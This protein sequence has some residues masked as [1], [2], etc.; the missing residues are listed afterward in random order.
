M[1]GKESWNAGVE[2]M[3]GVGLRIMSLNVAHGRGLMPVGFGSKKMFRRNLER[4]AEHIASHS[5]DIVGL[6]EVDERATATGRFNHLD[7]IAELA[8]FEHQAH[9]VHSGENGIPIKGRYGTALLSRHPIVRERSFRF[10][11]SVIDWKGA[12]EAT[13]S[14]GDSHMRAVS[15]HLDFLRPSVRRRQTEML[16]EWLKAGE[17]PVVVMGDFNCSLRG[18][19]DALRTLAEALELETHE[20]RRPASHT[21]PSISPKRRID[22]IFAGNGAKVEHY[23]THRVRLSDHL[24]VVARVRLPG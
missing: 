1:D 7:L 8:G 10:G 15:V 20:C 23:E 16:A 24:P 19:E 22:Y 11:T 21:F 18:R 2:T 9:A 12:L 3:E 14:V 4:I 17:H 13:V 6:Q 5:P